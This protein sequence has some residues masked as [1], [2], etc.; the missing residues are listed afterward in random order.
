[1]ETTKSA[2]ATVSNIPL[3]DAEHVKSAMP[4]RWLDALQR[5]APILAPA[6]AKIPRHVPCPIHGG[7]D[8]LRLY[9]DAHE[10]GG[11][12]CN[13][14]GPRHDGIALIM[15]ANSWDF[16]TTLQALCDYLGWIRNDGGATLPQAQARVQTMEP[17]PT[18]NLK[19]WGRIKQIA[20]NIVA[21]DHSSAK[22]AQL[23]MNQRG[24]G[25]VTHD[26]PDP[27]VVGFHP[28]LPYWHEGRH[29]GR[30]PAIVAR[31]QRIDGATMGL[32]CTYL[33]DDGAK[34]EVPE[35]KKLTPALWRG[36]YV[37]A[38]A[39]LYQVDGDALHVTEGIETAF[40]VRLGSG[41]PVWAGLAAG[42]L[43]AVQLPRGVRNVYIWADLDVSG[44]GQKAAHAL[45]DRLTDE[46]RSVR[47]ILPPG[48][49]PEGAK[50]L[51]WLDV[52]TQRGRI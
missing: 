38:A 33:S 41:G 40:A 48:A 43:E 1:M 31:V 23:Y 39:R 45:A 32:H 50:S 16:Q 51:D 30:Y 7:C 5:I 8:G 36:A 22:P 13:T 25:H 28:S 37:G 9:G 27:S 2:R 29:V 12:V 35:V 21:L 3:R 15:W 34:A 19:A 14:C 46:G 42:A 4:G 47:V 44:T 49:I 6:V 17:A 10:T 18:P 26:P 52:W 20:A 24:I 11:G